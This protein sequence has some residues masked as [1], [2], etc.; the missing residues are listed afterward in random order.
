MKGFKAVSYIS[1]PFPKLL[2]ANDVSEAAYEIHCR[3]KKRGW[4]QRKR[5]HLEEEIVPLNEV[6]CHQR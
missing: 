2:G 1:G 3:P 6:R 4:P 5:G